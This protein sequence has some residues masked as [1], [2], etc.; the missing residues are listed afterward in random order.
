MFRGAKATAEGTERYG[1]EN[2]RPTRRGRAD[3]IG[4][5]ERTTAIKCVFLG[6]GRRHFCA[7]TVEA[8]ASTADCAI[9]SRIVLGTIDVFA[10]AGFEDIAFAA[11][12]AAR[13]TRANST[14]LGAIN[15]LSVAR[16]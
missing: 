6:N 8:N 9:G 1:E 12:S 15:G 14:V 11:G 10:I 13:N 3:R 5:A 2:E 7:N 16:F 4:L